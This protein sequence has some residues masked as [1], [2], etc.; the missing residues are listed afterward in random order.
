[1]TTR[2]E[3]VVALAGRY[4]RGSRVERGRMLDEFAALTGHHRKHAMRLLRAG[5]ERGGSGPRPERRMYDQATRA[6]L[7]VIWEASTTRKCSQRPVRANIAGSSVRL[8]V[9]QSTCPAF[10][11]DLGT[12]GHKSFHAAGHSELFRVVTPPSC[13]SPRLAHYAR[14]E[15]PKQDS[16]VRFYPL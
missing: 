4:A 12:G 5:L 15:D 13:A 7:I 14:N 6:A 8:P 2:D 11:G 16:S 10:H 3:L 9:R 1:M